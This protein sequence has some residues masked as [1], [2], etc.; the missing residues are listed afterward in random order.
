[1]KKA[2]IALVFGL[3]FMAL[4]IKI[5][6]VDI[7]HCSVESKKFS[8]EHIT[9]PFSHASSGNETY[10]YTCQV[11]SLIEQTTK[12]G[13]AV[14]EK[15]LSVKINSNEIDL[16]MVKKQYGQSQLKDW[17]KGYFFSIPLLKGENTL[18]IIG[19]DAGG[20]F[21]ISIGQGLSYLE[22]LF[23]FI[24]SIIPIIFGI[25]SLLFGYLVKSV[26][27]IGLSDFSSVWKKL[28]FIIILAGIIL[29]LLFLVYI[30]NTMYQHDMGGHVDS[31]HYFSERPFEMPQ[32]DKSLQFPQQPLYYWMSAIV[33]SVSADFGFNEHDRIYSIRVMSVVFSIFWLFVGLKL[34]QLYTR[35]RLLINIFMAFLSFTPSFVFLSTVVNN[36]ALNA[37]LGIVSIY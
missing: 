21:G 5:N 34:I 8:R 22:Y 1:M 13:I 18:E 25:Y 3:V 19:S 23:L 31:I 20:R 4:F 30:P 26:R 14:D 37:L 32:A 10:R 11:E 29:R 35:K 2:Y 17:E 16:N 6:H 33:Y 36:D 27:H 15:L 28:P 24:F 12:I 7:V 9:L